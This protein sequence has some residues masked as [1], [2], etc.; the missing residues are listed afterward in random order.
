[1]AIVQVRNGY[2]LKEKT[3]RDIKRNSPVWVT[4]GVRDGRTW[5]QAGKRELNYGYIQS[6]WPEKPNKSGAIF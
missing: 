5:G 4:F 2:E 3:V 1:M 6:F